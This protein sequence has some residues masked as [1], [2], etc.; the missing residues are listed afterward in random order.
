MKV[1]F[2]ETFLVLIL[3]AVVFCNTV[4]SNAAESMLETRTIDDIVESYQRNPFRINVSV[5]DVYEIQPNAEP[6][7]VAGSLKREYLEEALNCVNF[8]RYLVGLP[9]DIELNDTYNNY[10]QHATIIL[11]RLNI[12]S[13]NPKKPD[14][15]PD[16]FYNL[17]Y[18]GTSKSNL[19]FGYSSLMDSIIGYMDD[20]DDY[21]IDKVGHRRWILNPSMA[22]IGFG[23]CGLFHSAYVFDTSRS[24][25]IKFDFISWPAR[26]YMPV[27]YFYDGSIPWSVN[28]GNYY[29]F[30]SPDNIE[31]TLTRRRDN[32]VWIFNKDNIEEYG[33]FNLNDDNY[34]MTKCII[35]RPKNVGGYYKN[36]VFDVNIKGI[37]HYTEGTAEINY[38]VEFFSL[39]DAI[40]EREKDFTY[41]DINGDGDI[42]SLDLTILKRYILRKAEISD[43]R[44]ADLDG[45][46]DVNSLDLTILKRYILRKIDKFPVEK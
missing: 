37:R 1:K 2:K 33:Y 14:D 8:L 29:T 22:K 18:R 19:A 7:Y 3:L 43:I 34:G 41:G 6:P 38:T 44:P 32:K 31:V 24:P 39:K 15:M 5:S 28:L 40:A 45:D 11:A 20:E 25:S 27:E 17:A 12:L 16:D 26:N 35:F 13:H 21:N 23:Q 36:D 4:Y 46:G 30:S 9:D 10:A 42:D